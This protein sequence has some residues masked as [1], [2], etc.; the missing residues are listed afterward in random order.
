[1]LAKRVKMKLHKKIGIIVII[2]HTTTAVASRTRYVENVPV[3]ESVPTLSLVQQ[4]IAA[5][6][7]ASA[8]AKE[9][10]ANFVPYKS[11]TKPT[12]TSSLSSRSIQL[13]AGGARQT[14]TPKPAAPKPPI[15]PKPISI[16]PEKTIQKLAPPKPPTLSKSKITL[17]PVTTGKVVGAGFAVGGGPKVSQE[18]TPSDRIIPHPSTSKTIKGVPLQVLPPTVHVTPS[19]PTVVHGVPASPAP[20][21][22]HAVPPSTVPSIPVKPIVSTEPA[23]PVEVPTDHGQKTPPPLPNPKLPEPRV[24]IVPRIVPSTPSEHPLIPG[25]P[26]TV[27]SEPK[28]VPK[29]IPGRPEVP[30]K[31]EYFKV[32]QKPKKPSVPLPSAAQNVVQH[33]PLHVTQEQRDT[34]RNSSQ[35]FTKEPGGQAPLQLAE[36]KQLAQIASDNL[37]GFNGT[38]PGANVKASHIKST[39]TK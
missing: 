17:E 8:L 7:A 32:P 37:H 29:N 15:S 24:P 26:K 34:Y 23:I 25:G 12:T 35:I 6:N 22:H 13:T 9:N 33:A 14:S 38:V 19:A 10:A 18:K 5:R 39:L 30:V 21:T 20:P 36:A 4:Q 3:E 1:M 28:I 11:R 27:P 2:V 16:F 31:P